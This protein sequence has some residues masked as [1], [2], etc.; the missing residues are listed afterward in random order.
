MERTTLTKQIATLKKEQNALILAHNYKLPEVQ[1]IADFV[2][3]SLDLALKATTHPAEVIVFCGVDF[4]A[5]AAHILNPQKVVVHPAPDSV[6]PMANMVDVPGL[7]Q[8]K[9]QHPN[10]PVV[11]YIN[12]T[13][14][15]KT[16]SDICCTSANGIKVVKTLPENKIIFVPDQNLG[17]YIQRFLPDKTMILWPGMCMTHH[18]I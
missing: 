5:E 2:G 16:E 12:T 18:N 17:S 4:M 1:D 3:D 13:A 15:I 11:S 14:E 6:C 7:Q 10:T 9:E 8:L